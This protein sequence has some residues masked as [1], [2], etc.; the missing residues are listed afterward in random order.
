MTL[1]NLV[2]GVSL[3]YLAS[4]YSHP[5]SEVRLQRFHLVCKKASELML[6]S[7]LVFSPVA[8]S[9]AIAVGWGLPL[10]FDFWGEFDRRMIQPCDAFAILMIPGWQESTGVQ[11]EAT[12]AQKF[13]KPTLFLEP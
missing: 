1:D 3:I 13:G 4:P 2:K 10:G 9:H 6:Q 7:Y 8:H 12:L 5:D 11:A